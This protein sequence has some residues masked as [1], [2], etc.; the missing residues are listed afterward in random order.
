MDWLVAQTTRPCASGTAPFV[1]L[2]KEWQL[3]E[4]RARFTATRKTSYVL[5]ALLLQDPPLRRIAGHATEPCRHLTERPFWSRGRLFAPQMCLASV[6]CA[7]QSAVGC[8]QLR[9][10]AAAD[11]GLFCG[12]NEPQHHSAEASPRGETRRPTA[13]EKQHQE[14]NRACPRLTLQIDEG[15][16]VWCAVVA[17]AFKVFR[18]LSVSFRSLVR[19]GKQSLQAHS[20]PQLL[21]VLRA[22]GQR[23]IAES[24]GF[25]T[26]FEGLIKAESANCTE[27]HPPQREC[28]TFWV[29]DLDD[30]EAGKPKADV[31]TASA[32]Q[33]GERTEPARTLPWMGWPLRPTILSRISLARM[34]LGRI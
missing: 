12:G 9:G 2:C 24:R 32:L 28:G 15:A 27:S 25:A 33:Q 23:R 20:K 16:K 31:A 18:V 17:P 14:S 1:T 30:L 8:S 13:P 10:H 6:D 11:S 5:A 29:Y 19:P 3:R 34:K 22:Y 26:N 21:K 7:Q 4:V